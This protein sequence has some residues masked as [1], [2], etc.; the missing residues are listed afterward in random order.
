MITDAVAFR[1]AQ[2]AFELARAER[3]LK[4]TLE[5]LTFIKHLIHEVPDLRQLLLNPDVDPDDKVGVLERALGA[6]CSAFVRAFMSLV[7]SRGRAESLPAIVEAFQSLVDEDQGRIHVIVRSA[8]HIPDALLSRLRTALEAK[9]HKQVRMETEIDPALIGG[10][11]IHL[12]HRL[13]DGS[14]R[15]QVAELRQQLHHVKVS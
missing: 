1:Y 9:E 13:I 4:E 15:R 5:Q 10:V 12:G 6:G 11:Q 7:V 3:G 14:V 2:A 8:R